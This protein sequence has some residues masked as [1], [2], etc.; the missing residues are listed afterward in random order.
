MI[1]ATKRASENE[2]REKLKKRYASRREPDVIYPAKKQVD[3]YDV[4]FHLYVAVYVRVSTD[5]I[6][7][8]TS[9]ELQKNYYEE[10]VLKHPN[11]TLVK[12][13][14]DQ[15]ITG[16]STKHRKELNQMLADCRA[17]KIDL[18]ITKSVSRLAR[19]TVDCISIVRSLAELRHPVGVFF[20][21]ECIFSLNEDTSMPLSSTG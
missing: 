6:G 16:T 20:E 15:G 3:F 13:Y 21:S 14:A 9:Y 11:W 17:G 19:N 2:E 4:D 5:N 18:I 7:Q 8:V 12:I 1:D 10:F